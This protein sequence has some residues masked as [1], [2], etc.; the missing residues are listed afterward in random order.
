MKY[1]NQTFNKQEVVRT[2][3]DLKQK[4]AFIEKFGDFDSKKLII[5]GLQ[6]NVFLTEKTAI[7]LYKNKTAFGYS[8]NEIKA[9]EWFGENK[10]LDFLPYLIEKIEDKNISDFPLQ[11]V[12][13]LEGVSF[14][15]LWHELNNDDKNSVF[16]D[17]G[18]KLAKIHERYITKPST[19]KEIPMDGK[20][21]SSD[22]IDYICEKD[23]FEK[24][25][26]FAYDKILENFPKMKLAKNIKEVWKKKLF[27]FTKLECVLTHCDIHEEQILIKKI[28]GKYKVSGIPDWGF[29]HITSPLQDFYF[30]EERLFPSKEIFLPE[31]KKL[32]KVMW[33]SYSKKRNLDIS[34]ED[35]KLLFNLYYLIVSKSFLENNHP[36]W[37][38]FINKTVREI[39]K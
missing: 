19:L 15:S 21:E 37:N 30:N 3:F 10:D 36:T 13:K 9:Y 25:I 32:R 22:W 14:F 28:N 7:L 18:K 29:A 16:E 33:K 4:K 8:K 5:S 11:V 39:T 31:I 23:Y 38:N 35:M 1:K 6:K 26:D 2:I 27:N 12:H 34:C 17:L 24:A 20:F